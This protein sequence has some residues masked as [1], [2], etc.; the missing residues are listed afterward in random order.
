MQ[1]YFSFGPFCNRMRPEPALL[2]LSLEFEPHA[3]QLAR[4]LQLIMGSLADRPCSHLKALSKPVW[5]L[6][7]LSRGSLETDL[8]YMFLLQ[9]DHTY[10]FNYGLHVTMH[11]MFY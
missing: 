5:T 6:Y 10:Q 9:P 4:P 7:G 11:L 3:L 1:M 8:Q 2:N